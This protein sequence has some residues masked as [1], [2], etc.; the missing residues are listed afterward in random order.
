MNARP[1][2]TLAESFD[3]GPRGSREN[4]NMSMMKC[5]QCGQ[6]APLSFTTKD[7]NRRISDERFDY[8]RCDA[9]GFIFL[10]PIPQDLGRF[11]PSQYYEIPHDEA[12]LADRAEESQRSKLSVVER[13]AKRGSLLEIGPAYGL[14]AYLAKR[15]GFDVTAIE[16]NSRCCAFLRDT[17]GITV[18][19]GANTP[20]LLKALPNFDVIVLWQVIEHLTDPW[21]VLSA[22]AQQ[23]APAGRLIIDTPNPAAFQFR[24]LGPRWTHIDAPRHV[25]LI[26]AALL[27]ERAKLCGLTLIEIETDGAIAKGYDSFGWAFSLKGYFAGE[28]AGKIAHFAGRV[29]AKLLAPIER[30]GRRGSTYTAV[31]RKAPSA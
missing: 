13:F 30:T 4:P 23:L 21:A 10:S 28:F 18:V 24:M 25:T 14:F 31:F 15:A 2:G 7:Y 8:Y 17:V 5:P 3:T 22:A 9:C 29:I 6:Q 11:Y 1:D 26:P 16:M 12:E 27:V 19:E 20:E